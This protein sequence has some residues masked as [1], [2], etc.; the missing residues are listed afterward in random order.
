MDKKI[1]IHY[2]KFYDEEEVWSCWAYYRDKE[3]I[4]EYFS[5]LEENMKGVYSTSPKFN[6]GN[7]MVITTIRDEADAALFKLT[8]VV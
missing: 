1:S 2:W 5:W 3:S 6:S 7:P 4:A 8:W